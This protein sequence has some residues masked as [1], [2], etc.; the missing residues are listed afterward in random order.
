MP[1]SRLNDGSFRSARA[2]DGNIELFAYQICGRCGFR[3]VSAGKIQR[4]VKINLQLPTP[5]R[6]LYQLHLQKLCS[7]SQQQSLR[8]LPATYIVLSSRIHSRFI[9]ISSQ[10]LTA[11]QTNMNSPGIQESGVPRLYYHLPRFTATVFFFVSLCKYSFIS[12]FTVYLPFKI[13]T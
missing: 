13:P 10:S 2:V 1:D 6:E 11:S 12:L 4:R 7:I 3:A 9:H 8:L 5:G